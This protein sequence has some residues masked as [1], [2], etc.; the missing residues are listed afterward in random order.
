MERQGQQTGP[1][2]Q[3]IAAAFA[4]VR[5]VLRRRDDSAPQRGDRWLRTARAEGVAPAMT[6]GP[7]RWDTMERPR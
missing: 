1:T 2:P 3:E 6:P 7:A 4:A 5:A